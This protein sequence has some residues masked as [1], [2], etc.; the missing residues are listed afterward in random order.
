MAIDFELQQSVHLLHGYT[1]TMTISEIKDQNAL[2]VWWDHKKNKVLQEWI[3][4]NVLK[5]TPV[6]APIDLSMFRR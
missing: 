5:K 2:C 1:P 4:L 3:P 6:K